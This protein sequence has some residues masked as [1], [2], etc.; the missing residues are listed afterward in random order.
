MNNEGL[1]IRLL[2]DGTIKRRLVTILGEVPLEDTTV[3]E[4]LIGL[5]D[6]NNVTMYQEIKEIWAHTGSWI[7]NPIGL[8]EFERRLG[9]YLHWLR[10]RNLIRYTLFMTTYDDLE[11]KPDHRTSDGSMGIAHLLSDSM[12]P[13]HVTTNALC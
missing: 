13:D 7:E 4:E 5:C 12:G 2:S 1:Y 3:A 8:R 10:S 6:T 11:T 9:D